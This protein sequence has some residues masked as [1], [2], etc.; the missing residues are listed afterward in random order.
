MCRSLFI[1]NLCNI[2]KIM[3]LN[4]ISI[5]CLKQQKKSYI[6]RFL[7][8][9]LCVNF[10]KNQ[11]KKQCCYFNA[12]VIVSTSAV[13][14]MT[15]VV[16]LLQFCLSHLFPSY[17][18]LF[19]CHQKKRIHESSSVLKKNWIWALKIKWYIAKTSLLRFGAS[20]GADVPPVICK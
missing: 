7:T 17:W 4:L 19:G 15:V 8:D 13:F 9:W 10:Y 20:V 12:A 3:K 18:M 2:L 1:L 11:E 6:L 16:C 14:T 5:Q